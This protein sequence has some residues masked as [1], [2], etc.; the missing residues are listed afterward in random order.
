MR[1]D[2]RFAIQTVGELFRPRSLSGLLAVHNKHPLADD[3]RLTAQVRA[4]WTS[5]FFFAILNQLER[6][7]VMHMKGAATHNGQKSKGIAARSR[8]HREAVV[9]TDSSPMKMRGQGIGNS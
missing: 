8:Y 4:R 2:E 7:T 6:D 5:P 1:I 9:I 3:S